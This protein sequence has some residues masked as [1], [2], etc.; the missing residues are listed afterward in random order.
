MAQEAQGGH[1]CCCLTP[2]Q[3][4]PVSAVANALAKVFVQCPLG[5]ALAAGQAG[6]IEV[7]PSLSLE[8]QRP[9]LFLPTLEPGGA[10]GPFPSRPTPIACSSSSFSAWGFAFLRNQDGLW[11]FLPCSD[12]HS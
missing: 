1:A 10:T 9:S 11:E 6:K 12:T 3:A 7:T 2:Q 4:P 5:P 8:A